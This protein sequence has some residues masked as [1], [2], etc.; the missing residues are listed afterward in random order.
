MIAVSFALPAESS[1]FLQRLEA[2]RKTDSAICGRIGKVEVGVCHTGVGAQ[3]AIEQLGAFLA[4]TKPSLLISSGF[5][6]G[7]VDGLAPGDLVLATGASA[8]DLF[9]RAEKLLPN[10]HTGKIHSA[11]TVVDPAAD[12][13][14]IG[15]EHYAIAVDMETDA[16]AQLCRERAMPLLVLRAI[17]DSPA[18]P[19]PAPPSV[20]FNIET[21]RTKFAD[22]LA[23]LARNPATILRLAQFSKQVAMARTKLADALS[24][25]VRDL[26]RLDVH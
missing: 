12:R 25:L 17:S 4:Q 8:A 19:F 10:A 21:Q 24:T 1:A 23:H 6:G 11:Q 14:A 18:A 7:T 20:L 2:R 15:R 13:Y 9:S 5:C 3:R 26:G 16:I 22:L